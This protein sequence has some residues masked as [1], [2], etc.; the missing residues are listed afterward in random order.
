MQHCTKVPLLLNNICRY[1]VDPQEQRQLN[2][3][4]EGLKTSLKKLEEK[5][6]WVKNYERVQLIQEQIVWPP[7]TELE[8]RAYIPEVY[9]K[10]INPECISN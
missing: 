1:T 5:M 2:E 10:K 3:S 7:I 8:P 4:L 6:N 9:K